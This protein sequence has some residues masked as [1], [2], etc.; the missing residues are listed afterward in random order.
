MRTSHAIS[1][2]RQFSR[3]PALPDLHHLLFSVCLWILGAG[4]GLPQET[5][6]AY[7]VPTNTPGNQT[8]LNAEP[9]GMDFDVANEIIVTRLG[10]FDAGSDGFVS[11]TVLTT[12]L[13]DRSQNPPAQLA[14][15]DFPSDNPGELVGGSRFKPLTTP[16][17]LPAGFQGTISADG[18]TDADTINNSFGNVAAAL[19][20]LNGGNGS[21]LFVGSSRFGGAAGDYPGTAD[22]G[23]AARFAAGTFEYQTTPPVL[24]GKPNVSV[25]NGDKQVVLS[26]PAVTLPP[27]AVK[28]HV[29]RGGAAAGPFTQNAEIADTTHTD[30][31]VVNGTA[32]YYTVEGITATD[33]IGPP[34]DAKAGTPYVLAANHAIAYFAPGNTLGNQP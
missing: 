10:V 22:S 34:S 25:R 30:T 9:I 29:N 20:T 1:R 21:I 15:I 28:Y 26:W 32:Y 16:I 14:S 8:G 24:P 18:W 27:P 33:R 6:I 17:H 11:G 12:R 4:A 7:V 31:N 2:R 5:F 19:W 3:G 13:W 23:P